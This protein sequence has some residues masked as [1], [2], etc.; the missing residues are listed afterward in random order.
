MN[1]ELIEAIA[2]EFEAAGDPDRAAGQQ[3][4]MKSELPYFG[5][6]TP[7]MR[8]IC[9]DCF[10]AHPLDNAD[11]WEGTILG[12]WREA[13]HREQ[14]YAAIELLGFKPYRQYLTPDLVPTLKELIVSG[15]WWDYVDGIAVN[16][17]G[18]LFADH[19]DIMRP[20]LEDWSTGDDMW[21]RR[22]AILAQ[23]KFKE[24][25]DTRLLFAFIEPSIGS[26]E[27]FLRKA[28]GWALRE[29]SKTDSETVIDYISSN[30]DR[31]SGLS[32]REGL[33][34][35]MKKGLVSRTDDVF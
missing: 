1:R 12:L 3:A 22:T 7:Q 31:L 5:I 28:I 29:Y 16:R 26:R 24:A 8:Q 34:I 33:K 23:L 17:I 35:L 13:G 18:Q 20:I 15:A 9:R 2:R 4:Y 27:F 6:T 32:K 25:T 19:P 10:N 14:R 11:A 30:K 21:L